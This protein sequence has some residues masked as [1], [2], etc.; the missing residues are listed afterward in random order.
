MNDG[1]SIVGIAA[2]IGDHARASMLMALMSGEALTATELAAEAG[3]SKQ[4]ASSHLAKLLDA[5]LLQRQVQGRHRYF[6]LSGA[7]VATLLEQLLGVAQRTGAKR[8]VPGPREPALRKARVCYDHL[9]GDLGVRLYD[10]LCSAG[11][12]VAHHD[13]KTEKEQVTL[14]TSGEQFF[15][16][17]GIDWKGTSSR[18]APCR[19]CLDWSSRRHHLA[20]TAGAALLQYCFTQKWAKRVDGTRVVRFTSR[21]EEAF[22]ALFSL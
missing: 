15:N 12:L 3:I 11:H 13:R 18:R 4:T 9:A 17:L 8:F 2:L 6:S 5:E 7:D 21:G 1:P 16:Q 22:N 19:A 20:G 14:T 10:S